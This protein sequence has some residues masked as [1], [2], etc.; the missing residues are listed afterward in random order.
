MVYQI[1][2]WKLEIFYLGAHKT[3]KHVIFLGWKVKILFVMG[4]SSTC[5]PNLIYISVG[6]CGGDKSSNGIEI[7]RFIQVLLHF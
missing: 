1:P 2:V 3:K 5:T 7:S 6:K 4:H